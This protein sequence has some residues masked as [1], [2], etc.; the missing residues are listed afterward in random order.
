MG[1]SISTQRLLFWTILAVLFFWFLGAI[2]SILLPFIVGILI[3][4]FLD[5]AAD[6]LEEWGL[7][8]SVAA[9]LIT[10]LFFGIII[11]AMVLVVP[12]LIHQIERFILAL[13]GYFETVRNLIDAKLQELQL[14]LH[15][16]D[17]DTG[18]TQMSPD[19]PNVLKA[20]KT[21]G[22]RLITSGAA[23]VNLGSLIVITPVVSF[24]LL[25]DWD[26][27]V[28][29]IR[30]LYPRQYAQTITEQMRLID[31]TISGFVRGVVNVMLLLSLFY[32]VGLS[33]VGL[34]FAILIG[35]IGGVM[36]IIPYI[37]TVV[38]GAAAVGLAYLQF[39]TLQPVLITLGIFTA[40]QLLEGYILTPKLVGDKIGLHP[41][42]LIFG[43]L[44]GA[45][46]FGFV[47][48]LLAI[49]VT[50]VIGVLSRFLISRYKQ[51]DFYRPVQSSSSTS[52]T[53]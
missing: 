28:A 12:A 18:D 6:R 27:I 48:I 44:A 17:I 31:Q 13:P 42:W 52:Q 3:A 5:P 25:R 32:A 15:R 39:D 2:Q 47:G 38:S 46:L 35:L 30:D 21:V 40:G 29:H 23:L 43:M 34:D 22:T 37:G 1:F 26:R 19:T 7:S 49:P 11:L 50:A 16:A 8:R 45:A 36:I 33:L 14:A 4:Y 20:V 10:G 41:L 53:Q 51:S 9:F 24:Y